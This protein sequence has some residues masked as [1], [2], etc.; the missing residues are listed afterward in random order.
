MTVVSVEYLMFYEILLYQGLPFMNNGDFIRLVLFFTVLIL[1]TVFNG[2]ILVKIT[3]PINILERVWADQTVKTIILTL[4]WILFPLQIAAFIDGFY[5]EKWMI[6]VT[7]HEVRSDSIPEGAELRVVH[8]SDLHIGSFGSR[9]AVLLKKVKDL[10]PDLILITGDYVNF[11]DR[12]EAALK[13]LRKIGEIAPMYLSSGNVEKTFHPE[14]E[15]LKHELPFIEEGF[16][17]FEKHGAKLYLAGT[18]EWKP[19][20]VEK[21][22]ELLKEKTRTIVNKFFM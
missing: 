17:E 19:G 2:L 7:R 22:A 4:F 21:S 12:Y 5:L 20:E 11:R 9:E 10:G 16:I 18:D 14:S 1:I 3:T 6:Q 13:T 8:L 15:L